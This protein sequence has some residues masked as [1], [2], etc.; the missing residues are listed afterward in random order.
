LKQLNHLLKLEDPRFLNDI[1]PLLSPDCACNTVR[2]GV[3]KW[4]GLLRGYLTPRTV[5]RSEVGN[6]GWIGIG[7]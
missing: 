1:T 6:E 7:K 3:S 2:A 5:S 4:Y